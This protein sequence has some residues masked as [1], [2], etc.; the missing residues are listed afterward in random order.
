MTLGFAHE[1]L[2]REEVEVLTLEDYSFLNE[3]TFS[4]IVQLTNSYKRSVE[5]FP[6]AL[7][8][9]KTFLS[10]PVLATERKLTLAQVMQKYPDIGDFKLDFLELG[11]YG[12]QQ[13]PGL[14]NIPIMQI[15]GWE[16]IKVSA[17]PG[18]GRVSIDADD[19]LDGSIVKLTVS[20]EKGNQKSVV[21]EDDTGLSLEWSEKPEDGLSPFG[22]YFIA[23][24]ISGEEIAVS[25]YFKSCDLQSLTAGCSMVG[26]FPY[27]E[28]T[29][30]DRIYVSAKDWSSATKEVQTSAP[31]PVVEESRSLDTIATAPTRQAQFIRVLIIAGIGTTLLGA[32]VLYLILRG[33]FRKKI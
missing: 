28:Y 29:V 15:P 11:Q 31:E 1:Y 14:L 27:G 23:P 12:A 16:D 17:I 2:S 7:V 20:S 19:N 9:L 4:E 18:L 25:A 8:A 22:S 21:L 24:T 10:H 32:L 3:T 13:I 26:P 6:L 33:L 30:G 5:H